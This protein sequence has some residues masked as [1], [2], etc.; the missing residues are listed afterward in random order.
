VDADPTDGAHPSHR[1][2]LGTLRT[3]EPMT[4]NTD[5]TPRPRRTTTALAGT[6]SLLLLGGLLLSGCATGTATSAGS[7]ATSGTTTSAATTSGSTVAA[8]AQ[9]VTSSTASTTAETITDTSA[10]V[11]AFLATLSEEQV[12]TV[13]YDYDDETKSTSWSN[14]P[15]TFVERAGLDVADLTEEQQVAALQVLEALLSDDGYA[16][17]SNIIAGDQYLA[18]TSSSTEDS[19]GRYYIALFG[20]ASSGTGA[21]EVQFGGHH[22]GI[23]ATLDADAD[24]ITFAPTHLGTQPEVWTS[25]DGT[26][27]E[28]FGTI[29]TTAFA[30]YDSLTDAQ[31]TALYQGED[32]QAMVCAPG[33][34]CTYPT[35][36]GL[37]GS[38]LTDEQK[39]LLLDVVAHWVGL[40][41]EQTTADA[42]AEIEATLDET[43]VSWSGATVYDMTQGDGIYFR[44]SGPKAYV[45][46]ASQQGSAGADV[47][48]VVTSGW[49]HVHTLYRDPSDDYANSVEQQAATGPAGGGAPA[50]G[51]PGGDGGTPPAGGPGGTPPSRDAATP[52]TEG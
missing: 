51:G 27:V 38:D 21:Y 46:L 29:Y 26:R 18:D 34:T 20:D 42:L 17:V 44:I 48:G 43:Y 50:G 23:N 4:T 25:A 8:A 2:H 7:S 14:F 11:E 1:I 52:P 3:I 41:D 24:A 10:A 19:L 12:D 16:T 31:K 45:E 49:G 13:T 36:T 47:E 6:T 32:V 37:A 9:R 28:T 40:A 39:Q 30:F 22:L 35:G 33:S 5:P 15:V